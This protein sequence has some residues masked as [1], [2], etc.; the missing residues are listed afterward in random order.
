MV[1]AY[2]LQRKVVLREMNIVV[3]FGSCHVYAFGV[4]VSLPVAFFVYRFAPYHLYVKMQTRHKY[5]IGQ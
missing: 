3:C 4:Y 2:R 1:F 5:A